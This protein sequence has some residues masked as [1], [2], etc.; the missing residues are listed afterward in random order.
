MKKVFVLCLFVLRY[1]S[2]IIQTPLLKFCFI[3][4]LSI[5]KDC[6]PT[7]SNR[8]VWLSSTNSSVNISSPTAS[9][10]TSSVY[11]SWKAFVPLGYQI[12]VHF[13]SFNITNSSNC[14]KASVEIAEVRDDFHKV[15]GRYCGKIPND[16]FSTYN[17]NTLTVIYTASIEPGQTHQGF[18]ASLM[19]VSPGKKNNKKPL[20]EVIL[21]ANISYN[22]DAAC[23]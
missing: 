16:V 23:A 12:K 10:L 4:Y 5:G 22:S 1:I 14:F 17:L 8:S 2:I 13:S 18:Y 15:L 3:L 21:F 20:R 9:F 11:C 19:L 7:M 6:T